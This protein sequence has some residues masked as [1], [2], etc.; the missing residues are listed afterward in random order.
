L[1][2]RQGEVEIGETCGTDEIDRLPGPL[3]CSNKL[4]GDGGTFHK[5]GAVVTSSNPTSFTASR[6][7][8][9]LRISVPVR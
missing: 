4:G 8:Y 2:D 9:I 3:A 7:V 6:T 5:L 1:E